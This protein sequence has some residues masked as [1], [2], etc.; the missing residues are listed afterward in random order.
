VGIGAQ[1]GMEDAGE[2]KQFIFATPMAAVSQEVLNYARVPL[3]PGRPVLEAATDLMHRIYGN[4]EFK[5]GYTTISTPLSIRVEGKEG[6]LPRFCSSGDCLCPVSRVA[7]QLLPPPARRCFAG[8]ARRQEAAAQ[9][10][11]RQA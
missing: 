2:I 7:C 3:P 8:G 11:D 1:E 9:A 5:S 10:K 4:F 6:S